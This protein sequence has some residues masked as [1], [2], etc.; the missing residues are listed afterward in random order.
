MPAVSVFRAIRVLRVIAEAAAGIGLS[1]LLVLQLLSYP[2]TDDP[3]PE[4]YVSYATYLQDGWS[5][6][7]SHWRLPGYPFFLAVV[8]RVGPGTMHGDVYWAQ[9]GLYLVWIALLWFAIRSRL[10]PLVAFCFLAIVAWPAYLTRHSLL[11]LADFLASITIAVAA[12]ALYGIVRART[13]RSAVPWLTAFGVLGMVTYLLH[14][15]ARI[16]LVI[17][18]AAM[19]LAAVV[20][21]GRAAIGLAPRLGM[22]LVV[23]VVV[24]GAA[25]AWA[26]RGSGRYSF[27]AMI[28]SSLVC[29]PPVSDTAT[30]R[31]IEEAKAALSARLG[32]PAQHATPMN[33]PELEFLGNEVPREELDALWRQRLMAQ[34]LVQARCGANQLLWRW[35]IVMRQFAPF[36]PTLRLATLA[37]LPE[38]GSPRSTLYRTTGLELWDAPDSVTWEDLTSRLTDEIVRML[39]TV[40]LIVVGTVALVRRFREPALAV[41]IATV[42]WAVVVGTTLALEARY[43]V[44]SLPGIYLAEAMAMAMLVR[45]AVSLIPFGDAPESELTECESPVR[46]KLARDAQPETPLPET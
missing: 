21:R 12:F 7:A 4:G 30:D 45:W 25:A 6:P 44:A 32:Y 42:V 28:E 15:S 40:V 31:R 17:L 33:Y 41:V 14:P 1:A 27:Y 43:L 5:L 39:R 9:F 35:H 18:I 19:A 2:P 38:T 37:Y 36:D 29:L 34:P 8:D 16:M 13:V 3:D 46:S 26:D 10:G 22:A 20:Y 23:L 11:M 24:T